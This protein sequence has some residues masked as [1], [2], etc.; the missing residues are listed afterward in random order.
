MIHIEWNLYA[1]L[2]IMS[3]YKS[4]IYTNNI[5]KM[6][7]SRGHCFLHQPRNF[8]GAAKSSCTYVMSHIWVSHVPHMSESCPTYQWVMSHI[9]VS[10]GKVKL[11]FVNIH[12]NRIYQYVEHTYEWYTYMQLQFFNIH[13]NNIY[14]HVQKIHTNNIYTSSCNLS[15]YL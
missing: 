13:V 4:N 1:Q 3:I 9:W 14:Q 8:R 6:Q 2:C 5:C 10:H 11:R 12:V 7:I 15:I